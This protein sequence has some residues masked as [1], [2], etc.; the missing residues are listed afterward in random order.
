MRDDGGT[1][2]NIPQAVSRDRDRCANGIRTKKRRRWASVSK[3]RL[4]SV[5]IGRTHPP[6]VRR[7]ARVLPRARMD[8]AGT[9]AAAAV[10]A[11]MLPVAAT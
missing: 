9:A 5:T 8:S 10:A 3:R 11:A 2:S 7:V 4:A 1:V 6:A